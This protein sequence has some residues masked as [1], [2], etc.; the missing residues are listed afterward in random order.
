MYQRCRALLAAGVGDAGEARRWGRNAV[1]RAETTGS[2][3]DWLE[4]Q[5]A[6]G[7]AA[8][9]SR[10]P[11]R[12][13]EI[14]RPVWEH[15][16]R[17]DLDPGVFPAAPELVEALADLG[18]LDAAT[19]VAERLHAMAERHEHPWALAAAQ[20][21]RA[22][23]ALA[24]PGYDADAAQGLADAAG[25]CADLGLAFD[26]ARTLLAL[27]RAQRRV[28]QWGVAR[29]SLEDAAA[30]FDVLGSAGWAE[31]ARTD[32]ARV[33]G[34]PP[35]A[36]GELTATEREIVDL[37]V[38]GLANKEIARAL[39]LAVHTVEVH[40]SRIYRKLGVTSRGQLAARLSGRA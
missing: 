8:L 18:E 35:R 39:H 27:G 30:A 38:D 31:N 22:V 28:K 29:Q 21:C 3:W 12:A 6:R 37:A 20:R 17:E 13:A 10:E 9:V 11:G 26:H 14:L 33:G 7:M 2:R 36:S 1:A 23:V 16:E 4:A 15:V 40:L 32:L 24:A 34:R 25:A 19:R 5:R